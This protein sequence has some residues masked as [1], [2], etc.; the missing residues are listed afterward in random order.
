MFVAMTKTAKTYS[1][2]QSAAKASGVL[3]TAIVCW[4][5]SYVALFILTRCGFTVC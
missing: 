3:R 5:L 4:M 1:K 2:E